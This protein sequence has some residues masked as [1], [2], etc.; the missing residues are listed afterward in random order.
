M[1]SP[2]IK[3]GWKMPWDTWAAVHTPLVADYNSNCAEF[4][5]LKGCL[6]YG[7]SLGID[8]KAILPRYSIEEEIETDD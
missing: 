5:T 1:S 8:Y 2:K 6:R 3:S 4:T 7:L